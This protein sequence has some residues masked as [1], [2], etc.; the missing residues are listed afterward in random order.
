[1]VR[2]VRAQPERQVALYISEPLAPVVLAPASGAVAYRTVLTPLR[3][4]VPEAD[5]V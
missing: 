4:Y 3:Y 5:V 2:S 1:L